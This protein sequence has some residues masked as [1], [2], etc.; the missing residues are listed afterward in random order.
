MIFF[1]FTRAGDEALG[2]AQKPASERI[3]ARI[4]EY[5]STELLFEGDSAGS[6]LTDDAELL[7]VLDSFGLMQLVTFIE[8]DLHVPIDNADITAANFRTIGDIGRLVGERATGT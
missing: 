3:R 8:Q 6:Q 1:S 4:R 7:S 2:S 5:I